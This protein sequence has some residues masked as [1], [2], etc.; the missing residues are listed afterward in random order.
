M[1]ASSPERGEVLVAIM[2]NAMDFAIAIEKHWYRIPVPSVENFLKKRWPP[3]WL[4]FYQTKIFGP[5]SFSIHYYAQV[6]QIRR[7]KRRELFPED[8]ADEKANQE[9]YQIFIPELVRL[10]KPILSRRLRRILFIPTTWEKFRKAV[11]INDLYDESPLE[12]KLWAAFKR[13]TIT[14]ERQELVRIEK[15]NYIL[16]FAIHCTKGNV[17][18]ETDGDRWHQE[19]ERVKS[20]KKRDNDLNANGW[21]TL[22]FTTKQIHEELEGYCVKQVRDAIK[23]LG[24]LEEPGKYMPRKIHP[25]AEKGIYQPS[26]F[27]SRS[28]YAAAPEDQFSLDDEELWKWSVGD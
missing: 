1:T 25:L 2:N 15:R 19:P 4:A 16:D 11:E 27:E 14:A 13:F 18:V 28:E 20:D 3:K 26:L 17:D 24:G 7:V 10:D 23:N 6:N 5:E 21:H 12:D 22:R 8:F 9:Y